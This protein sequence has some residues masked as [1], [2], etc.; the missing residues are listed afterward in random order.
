MLFQPFNTIDRFYDH[1]LKLSIF[2]RGCFNMGEC[3]K[4][5]KIT[6]INLLFWHY[7]N[8]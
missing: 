5:P 6:F 4:S 8:I 1:N 3:F 7:V 2:K